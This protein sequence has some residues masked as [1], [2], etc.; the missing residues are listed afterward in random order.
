MILKI[1][2]NLFSLSLLLSLNTDFKKFLTKN[3]FIPFQIIILLVS[4]TFSDREN[5]S[6]LID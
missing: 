6:F 4:R 1:I 3:F 2:S 5:I